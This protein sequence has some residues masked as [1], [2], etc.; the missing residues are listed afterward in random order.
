M[1]E[2]PT[3]AFADEYGRKKSVLISFFLL[4]VS[5]LGFFLFE[6]F[7]VLAS[8]FFLQD[9]AWTFQS[10]ATTAWI[11]D[12]LRIGNHQKKIV[13]VFSWFYFFEKVGG[14][15]GGIGGFFLAKSGLEYVWLFVAILNLGMF[16]LLWKWMDENAVVRTRAISGIVA[17]TVVKM[18]ESLLFL[19]HIKNGRTRGL[20]I[21]LFLHTIARSTISIATPIILVY[22]IGLSVEGV[23]GIRSLTNFVALSGLILCTVFLRRFRMRWSLVITMC[24]MGVLSPVFSLSTS[25]LG[26]VTILIV[27]HILDVVGGTLHDSAVQHSISSSVR[28]SIGSVMGVAWGIGN[29]LGVFFAG[30]GIESLGIV[31]TL[32]LAGVV[33]F[34]AAVVYAR[35]LK[36]RTAGA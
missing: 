10:G 16:V 18:K 26:A 35:A 9:I 3:G 22:G 34:I 6:N 36:E 5:F 17:R 23:V 2:F 1:C 15:L 29:A 8:F 20:G 28:A 7:W 25:I 24:V 27:F 31:W 19:F 4:F 13:T 12:V 32:T 21:A 33:F 14:V 11:V 30:V